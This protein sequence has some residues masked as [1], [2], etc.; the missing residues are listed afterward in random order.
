MPRKGE[1]LVHTDVSCTAK[2][3]DG[4]LCKNA[5][6]MGQR[7]CRMHGGSTQASRAKAQERILAAAD[8]AAAKLV[9]LMQD[10]RVPH[11][12][13]LAAARDLLDR[14]GLAV[15]HE[16]TLNIPA[17]LKDIEGIFVDV[18]EGEVVG[19][20]A[21]PAALPPGAMDAEGDPLQQI[22]RSDIVQGRERRSR[23]S[24]ASPA[25]TSSKRKRARDV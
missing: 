9:S 4:D 8:P 5:P 19:E 17:Y 24:A 11:N 21:S 6:M 2:T 16:I 1:E 3:R 18:V 25:P 7:T 13:Q 12:V 14:A 22:D 10:K 20:D 23:S 15:G